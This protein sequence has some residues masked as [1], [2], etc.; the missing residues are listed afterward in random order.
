MTC[1]E[2]VLSLRNQAVRDMGF[3]E[4]LSAEC[5]DCG[6]RLTMMDAVDLGIGLTPKFFGNVIIGFVC[7]KCSTMSEFHWTEAATDGDLKRFFALPEDLAP[8][9]VNRIELDRSPV[10]VIESRLA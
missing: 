1:A 5:P 3:P 6:S 4:W 2:E 10:G 8:E 7:P 9:P